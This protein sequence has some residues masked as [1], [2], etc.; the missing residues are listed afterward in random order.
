VCIIFL[1]VLFGENKTVVDVAK[2]KMVRERIVS[3]N[4]FKFADGITNKI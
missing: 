3:Y 4:T 1:L 2:E